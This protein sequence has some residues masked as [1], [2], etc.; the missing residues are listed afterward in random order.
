MPAVV[1]VGQCGFDHRAISQLFQTLDTRVLA[2]DSAAAALVTIRR[3]KPALVLVNRKF[4]ANGDDGVD[5][6]RAL[7]KDPELAQIPVMLVSNYE[8][9]QVQ[10]VAAGAERGFGKSVLAQA[11]TRELVKTFLVSAGK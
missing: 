5:F 7:K 8:D 6:I 10:A 3:E 2:A 4:D 1:S 9:A 11:E